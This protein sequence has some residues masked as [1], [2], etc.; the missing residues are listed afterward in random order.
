MGDA[1]RLFEGGGVGGSLVGGALGEEPG[2]EPGCG[3]RK[4][5]GTAVGLAPS[6][7]VFAEL[8]VWGKKEA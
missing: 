8:S 4:R 6:D 7:S 5:E 2:K 3:G 1:L